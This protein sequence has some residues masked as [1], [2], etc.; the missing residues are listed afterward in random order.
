MTSNDIPNMRITRAALR[1]SN[2]ITTAVFVPKTVKGKL[3]DLLQ[4][5]HSDWTTKILEKP[6]IQLASLFVKKVDMELGCWRG[7]ECM[8]EGRGNNCTAKGVVYQATCETCINSSPSK[9]DQIYI[10]ETARQ[11]L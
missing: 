5:Q 2:R 8:C 4:Q 11:G 7:E 1:N 6:G 10:G 9:L 3:A